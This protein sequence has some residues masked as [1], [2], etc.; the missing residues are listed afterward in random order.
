MPD[1][2]IAPPPPPDS[3]DVC[4]CPT[5]IKSPLG[6]NYCAT[7]GKK[8]G[9]K[10][11]FTPPPK[12]PAPAPKPPRPATKPATLAPATQPTSAVPQAS[13]IKPAKPVHPLE[14]RFMSKFQSLGTSTPTKKVGVTPQQKPA[15]Q[16]PAYQQPAYQQPAYQQPA[17]QQPAYQQP[18]YKPPAQS[19][20][21][22][23]AKPPMKS[24]ATPL[25][26]PGITPPSQ[27][28]DALNLASPMA[29]GSATPPPPSSF[30]LPTQAPQAA[31]PQ[32]PVP[33][34][35]DDLHLEFD[36][37]KVE[38]EMPEEVKRK[39]SFDASIEK[40]K[41]VITTKNKMLPYEFADALGI[42]DKIEEF[43]DFLDNS[44][45]KELVY[46]EKDDV[47]INKT[48]IMGAMMLGDNSIL[49][50]LVDEYKNW[51]KQHY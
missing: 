5:P 47:K 10:P 21:T 41:N 42:P 30:S 2:K 1:W 44:V 26:S 32:K 4:T 16:Q 40:F 36:I 49:D 31:Q 27:I 29:Q 28:P 11:A 23:P 20:M 46:I 19:I 24:A 14:E 17:Y 37:A 51:L 9:P 18:A 43:Y 25:F 7:C 12:P 13:T 48:K 22:K 50:K 8:I 39:I 35:G 6:G 45:D 33:A 15:Y 38:E 34:R 3:T